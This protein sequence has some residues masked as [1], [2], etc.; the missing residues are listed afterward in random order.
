MSPALSFGSSSQVY[1]AS[2]GRD[3]TR[4]TP[5]KVGRLGYSACGGHDRW[6]SDGITTGNG[7][8]THRRLAQADLLPPLELGPDWT[9]W[10]AML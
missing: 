2:A 9:R 8:A 7:I 3:L 5:M 6:S 4:P 10:K 1:G